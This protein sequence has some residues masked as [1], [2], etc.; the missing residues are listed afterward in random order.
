MIHEKRGSARVAACSAG[1]LSSTVGA[2]DAPAGQRDRARPNMDSQD[3]SC[4][5][6]VAPARA[7]S[8]AVTTWAM[9]PPLGG[10]CSPRNTTRIRR[11]AAKAS[12]MKSAAPVVTPAIG[13]GS[14]LHCRSRW[15]Y[16]RS[17]KLPAVSHRRTPWRPAYRATSALSTNRLSKTKPW[18][19]SQPVP[20]AQDRAGSIEIPADQVRTVWINCLRLVNVYPLLHRQEASHGQ[21]VPRS[22]EYRNR[23]RVLDVF[24]AECTTPCPKYNAE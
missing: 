23:A 10:A 5:P 6:C 9:L 21:L 16:H 20:I 8:G 24:V 4:S 14:F 11:S 18:R 12:R 2:M 1:V 7:P 15:S 13:A 19:S 17:V 3:C 22:P